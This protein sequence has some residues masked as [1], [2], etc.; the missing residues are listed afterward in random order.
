MEINKKN[1]KQI[2]K[3][4]STIINLYQTFVS[5][6]IPYCKFHPSCS[7]YALK[8]IKKHGFIIGTL[9]FCKRIIKCNLFFKTRIDPVKK[10]KR[11]NK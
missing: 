3:L 5:P 11:Y 6:F 7:I 8:A 2:I 10:K 4:Y 1:C 9:F